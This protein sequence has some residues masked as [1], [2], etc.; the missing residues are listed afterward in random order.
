MNGADLEKIQGYFKDNFSIQ[1]TDPQTED[2]S[3]FV[4][5]V[6]N[7]DPLTELF[8]EISGI[9]GIIENEA[10]ET[11]RNKDIETIFDIIESYKSDM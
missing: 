9:L 8:D 3:S 1:L 11:I 2:I 7:N 6:I 10:D 4:G 5:T